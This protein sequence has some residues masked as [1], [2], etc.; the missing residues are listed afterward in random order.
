MPEENPVE[1]PPPEP[2]IASPESPLPIPVDEPVQPLGPT[3]PDERITLIDIL[4]GLA[5]FGIIMANM[6]GFAGP[7]MAYFQPNL[8]WKTRT[9]F[10]VQAFIDTF[11]QGKF[12]TIFAF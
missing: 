4:R 9:D 5:L 3:Q 2:A 11:I 6:R 7:L 8:I 12:I 10:W 1:I